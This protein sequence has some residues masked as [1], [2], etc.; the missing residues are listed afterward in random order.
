MIFLISFYG[1]CCQHLQTEYQTPC[2]SWLSSG[3]ILLVFNPRKVVLECHI[4]QPVQQYQNAKWHGESD[5]CRSINQWNTVYVPLFIATCRNDIEL[6]L[7][8]IK[9]RN[10]KLEPTFFGCLA[11]TLSTK[12]VVT[13]K[14][15]PNL[16]PFLGSRWFSLS[17]PLH[18]WQMRRCGWK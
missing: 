17:C 14:A 9:E 16:F 2:D 4:D 12:L 6:F 7:R 3:I 8:S 15:Q 10:Q 13:Q 11:L 5:A 1:F 18:S